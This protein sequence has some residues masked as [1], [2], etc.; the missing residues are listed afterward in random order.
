MAQ[1]SALLES[2]CEAAAIIQRIRI[3]AGLPRT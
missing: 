3:A 2:A 1:R